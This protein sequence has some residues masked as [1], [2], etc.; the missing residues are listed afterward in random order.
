ME[1]GLAPQLAMEGMSGTYFL[2]EPSGR[3][4][5]A[6]VDAAAVC[7]DATNASCL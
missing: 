1:L 3:K 7:L 5:G 2:A 4:V 6:S